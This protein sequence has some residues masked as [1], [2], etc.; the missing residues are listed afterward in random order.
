MP[1]TLLIP[2]N[3]EA[4]QQQFRALAEAHAQLQRVH[5]ELLDTCTSIQD[6][7]QKLEQERDELQLTIQRLLHQWYGRRSERRKEGE[8]QRHLDFGDFQ[9][10]QV[11]LSIVSAASDAEI[12]TEYVVRRRQGPREPRSEQ[13]PEHLERRTE[14][15]EPV[16]PAGVKAEDFA[17]IGIDVVEVLQFDRAKMWVRRIEYPKYKIPERE[18]VN[19]GQ[20]RIAVPEAS[21]ARVPASEPQTP[22]RPSVEAAS[23]ISKEHDMSPAPESSQPPESGREQDGSANWAVTEG[24]PVQP[25][26]VE[27]HGILQRR[28]K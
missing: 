26:A 13:L 20:D 3:L 10:S 22:E 18:E 19:A 2:D 1:E 14:R 28:G 21:I 8:G 27:P 23:E 5:E 17:L 12:I 7:Q 16:F 6:A 15:I 24:I 11:D 25:P 4:C 9:T